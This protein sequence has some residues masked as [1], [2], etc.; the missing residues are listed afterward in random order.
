MGPRV[1]NKFSD[2]SAYRDYKDFLNF[3]TGAGTDE[4]P[5]A[6]YRREEEL[7]QARKG[8]EDVFDPEGI[9]DEDDEEMEMSSEDKETQTGNLVQDGKDIATQAN[10][11][12]FCKTVGSQTGRSLQRMSVDEPDLIRSGQYLTIRAGRKAADPTMAIGSTGRGE[13]IRMKVEEGGFCSAGDKRIRKTVLRFRMD[14]MMVVSCSFDSGSMMCTNCENR[15]KHSVLNSY[16]GGPV[17]FIGTDQHFPAVLPSLDLGSCMSIVRVE[18]GGLRDIAWTIIDLLSGINLPPRSTILIGSSSSIAAKGI[19]TYGEDMAWSIRVIR[20]KL[21]DGVS[22]SAVVPIFVNGVNNPSLVRC[23]A[24][25]E[26]WFE[27]LIGPD[28]ALMRKTRAT[29][30]QEMEVQGRGLVLS[31]EENMVCMP[32]RLVDFNRVPIALMGWRTMAEQLAPFP[33]EAEERMVMSM[34][35]ELEANFGVRVSRNLDLRRVGTDCGAA[36]YVIIGGSNGG[37][38]GAVLKTKGRDVIDMTEKG[39]RVKEDSAEK[40][41]EKLVSL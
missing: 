5:E 31:P 12:R 41:I 29:L 26:C 9:L 13:G 15:G 2:N 8:S 7:E 11:R 33:Q 3:L 20:E 21:G 38:L 16:D 14:E 24:E 10:L 17:V 18:D 40:L 22:V 34:R 4:G 6:A 32:D 37:Q 19:Q 25:A 35:D 39:F 36:D 23:V 28:G 30:L 1:F 27:G